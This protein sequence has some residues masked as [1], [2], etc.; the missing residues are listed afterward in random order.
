MRDRAVPTDTQLNQTRKQWKA[1][2]RYLRAA[3]DDA[4][5]TDQDEADL[6]AFSPRL[7]NRLVPPMDWV[8]AASTLQDTISDPDLSR[9]SAPITHFLVLPPHAGHVAVVDAW[10]AQTGAVLVDPPTAEAILTGDLR[11]LEGLKAQPQPWAIARLEKCFLRHE[12]GLTLVRALLNSIMAGQIGPGVIGCDSWA[13]AYLQRTL[14]LPGL[15]EW[16]LQALDGR[17][18]EAHFLSDSSV[19]FL[20]ARNGKSLRNQD[21]KADAS[22]A[23]VHAE[24][25]RLVAHCRG[26]PGVAWQYWR[27]HLRSAPD[28]AQEVDDEA[29]QHPKKHGRRTAWLASKIEAPSLPVDAEESLTLVL[30]ALLIHGGLSAE[31]LSELLPVGRGAILSHLVRLQS[32]DLVEKSNEDWR[33]TARGYPAVREFLRGRDYLTDCF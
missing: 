12:S 18:F 27:D 14:S 10:A 13:W 28:A 19:D 31:L 6:L 32:R 26:N 15:Y 29:E 25:V 22:Q 21:S 17:A 24:L 9:A 30:H 11:W 1:L 5:S 23:P 2:M 7:Q 8:G 4:S 16:T 33:V 20:S 3:D